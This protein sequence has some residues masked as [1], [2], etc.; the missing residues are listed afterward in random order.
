M[1]THELHHAARWNGP[2]YGSSLGEALVSEGLAGHFVIQVFG[3]QPEAWECIDLDEM[4]RYRTLA[5][6]EWGSTSY[7]YPAWFFGS[8]D[9]PR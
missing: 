7:N 4:N 6:R 9:L 2:G 3:G 1:F 5:S 8:G